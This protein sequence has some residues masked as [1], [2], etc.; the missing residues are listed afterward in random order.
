VTHERITADP[1]IANGSPVIQGSHVPLHRILDYAATGLSFQE[2]VQA[3]PEL[4]LAD[5]QAALEYAADLLRQA[6]AAAQRFLG[7]PAPATPGETPTE[8]DLNKILVVD[9]LEMNRLYM[10]SMFRG[11]KYTLVMASDGQEALDKARTEAPFLIISDIFMPRMNGLELLSHIK[12]DERTKNTAVILVTAQQRSSKRASEGLD[13]GADDYI[14]RP[15]ERDELL[16]RV[17]AVARLRQ[18]EEEA[19]RQ[20]RMVAQ[21]NKGLE[22]LN[23]LALAVTSALNLREIF[24]SSTQKLS[25]LLDAEAVSLLLINEEQQELELNLSSY[26]GECLSTR[27]DFSPEPGVTDWVVQEQVPDILLEILNDPRT[28]FK[29]DS[30]D[31]SPIIVCLP[32][33]TKDLIVGAIAIINKRGETF[34][35]AD[36]VLLNSAASIVAVAV[37]N[38]RLLQDITQQIAELT[39]LNQV[40]QALTSTLNLDQLLSQTTQMVQRYLRA[41]AASLWLLDEDGQT[42][43]LT[44]SSG[45]GAQLVTGFRLPV[46]TG[47]AGYVART[48]EPYFSADVPNDEKFYQR[49]AEV[50]DYTPGSIL[51]VP[52]LVKGHVI[53]VVQALHQQTHWFDQSDMRL[54][55]SVASSVGIAVENAQLFRQVQDFNRYLEQ[56][57]DERTRQLAQEK[58]KTEAIL[59]SMADGLLV[60]DAENRIMMANTMAEAML[61]FDLNEAQGQPIGPERLANPLWRCVGD[62]TGRP[63]LTASAGVD[64][65]DASRLGGCRSIQAHA[66]RVRDEG[67]NVIGTVIVLRDITALKEVERIKARFMA[68]VTHELKTPLSVIRLHTKNLQAYHTRLPE[69]KRDELLDAIH[70]QTKLLEQLVENILELAHLDTGEVKDERQPVDLVEVTEQVLT[71]LGPLA[72]TKGIELKWSR[73]PVGLVTLANAG[74]LERVIRNL[75]DNGIKY[76]PVGGSVRVQLGPRG[77]DAVEICVADTGVGVPP[78]HQGRIFDRFYRVDPSHTIPGTGLGLSIVK[79]IVSAHGG[80]VRLESNPGAGSTF[81]IS[82]PTTNQPTNQPSIPPT[83]RRLD[84]GRDNP[85]H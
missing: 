25:Q 54:L 12:A 41:E 55:H 39:L 47:I 79:E 75:V 33:A 66:A 63:E 22:L 49:V 5:V 1:T 36:W 9:D 85:N 82:L 10:R 53:G 71:D 52:V 4:K 65:P 80:D 69:H 26:T 7:L 74:Q 31:A 64:V 72:R 57:V 34:A 16:S 43:V 77:E 17:R 28:D 59:A 27:V 35:A 73:P 78:R 83:Q 37:E 11:S 13:L 61:N 32:M 48:G 20:A 68:G 70:N 51:C 45:P 3:L 21:R 67:E 24:A 42:L 8:L 6:P 84:S 44:T 58:E 38:A 50:S 46:D 56:M 29:L 76:T 62:M 15:F 60:L 30:G 2:I 81:I 19:R 14:F 40:G 23:E 18:A